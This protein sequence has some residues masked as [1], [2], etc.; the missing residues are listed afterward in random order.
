MRKGG[1][2]EKCQRAVKFGFKVD[3]QTKK[4]IE[5]SSLVDPNSRG[6]NR[7]MSPAIP[8]DGWGRSGSGGTRARPEV[9]GNIT[10]KYA[11]LPNVNEKSFN[12][13]GGGWGIW[14]NYTKY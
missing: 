5:V 14:G 7:L 6:S 12:R 9:T 13:E 10:A 1:N 2:S 3:F 11:L 8:G 4:D